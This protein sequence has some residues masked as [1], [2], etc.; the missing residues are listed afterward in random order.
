M[1]NLTRLTI[2]TLLALGLAAVLAMTLALAARPD[3]VLAEDHPDGDVIS[4]TQTINGTWGPGVITATANVTIEPGVVITIAPDTIIRVADGVGFTV[5]GDLHSDGPITFTT[6][7]ST[8][9]PGAWEG[10][11]YADGS[12]GYLH[13]ATVEYGEHAI[14]L[15]TI[16]QRQRLRM[17]LI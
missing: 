13:E 1:S 2:T 14:V 9:V 17:R 16:A 5:Q 15:S 6:A 11:T 3:V 10:I 4:P 7:S 12:T 8:A